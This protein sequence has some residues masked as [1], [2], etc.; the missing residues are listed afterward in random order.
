MFPSFISSS[1]TP[2]RSLASSFTTITTTSTRRRRQCSPFTSPS[3]L[4]IIPYHPIHT[5]A[6]RTK[7][8]LTLNSKSKSKYKTKSITKSSSKSITPVPSSKSEEQSE[9]PETLV[10]LLRLKVSQNAVRKLVTLIQEAEQQGEQN[11][12]DGQ[13]PDKTAYR[14]SMRALIR[15][16]RADLA[17]MLWNVRMESALPV[18]T[19]LGAATLRCVLRD[20]RKRNERAEGV[21][22]I[23]DTL[24]AE[25]DRLLNM[26]FE[27]NTYEKHDAFVKESAEEEDDDDDE[28][29]KSV[30]SSVDHQVENVEN[31]SEIVLV[32][33]E[34]NEEDNDDDGNE[35]VDEVKQ[36]T[37][38][39]A[40]LVMAFLSAVDRNE[41]IKNQDSKL[42][43]QSFD[44]LH[45][46]SS[47]FTHRAVLS[48]TDY[49][50]L[51][52]ILGKARKLNAVF[53]V[54]DMMCEHDVCR[55]NVTFEHLSNAALRQVR[56]ITGAVS[57]QTLPS[58]QGIPE[59]AFIGR[60]NVGKSSLVNM[61]CN[62]KALAKV[63]RRPGKTQQFNYFLVNENDDR[64]HMVDLPGVG[65][66]KVPRAVQ[67]EWLRFMRQYFR[68]R[69][70]L[71]LV[72][73]LVDGRHGPLKDDV[74][75]MREM[76]IVRG[77]FK[78]VI[79]LTKM[80]KTGGKM[81]KS[82]ILNATRRAL[83]DS[84]CAEDTP[85]VV[86][87]ATTKLG[88]DDMWRYLRSS[89]LPQKPKKGKSAATKYWA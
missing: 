56:F 28:A 26:P 45:Q 76:G 49:N 1:F 84:G 40:N 75:L 89:I 66:A 21:T 30:C 36:V 87:S 6:A 70:D 14:V 77:A 9:K 34:D 22:S 83:T 67:M 13:L 32:D 46:L 35:E 7:S 72:F 4:P 5:N 64:F 2:C 74:E 52:R 65:Y 42:A 73:H 31:V 81:A 39:F 16:R 24:T 48:I 71:S 27:D 55:D 57:M 63:S 10:E 29:E 37:S 51:L 41:V 12:W 54:L 69:D 11:E 53:T 3:T 47:H 59:V 17:T 43:H 61:V 50:E 60:S 68:L 23:L 85:I 15:A 82:S 19:N 44:K 80:D 25:A 88:R 33:S 62:R 8:K 78:Y 79:V 58:D 38:S 20:A 86:T 18:D